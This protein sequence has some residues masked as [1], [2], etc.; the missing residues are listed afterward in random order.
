MNTWAQSTHRTVWDGNTLLI[1][2]SKLQGSLW[3][4]NREGSKCLCIESVFEKEDRIKER[5]LQVRIK[6]ACLNVEQ[7]NAE[8]PRGDE[9]AGSGSNQISPRKEGKGI[10]S[11]R[12]DASYT[13]TMTLVSED[14][15][16]DGPV[17]RGTAD[18]ENIRGLVCPL[19]PIQLSAFKFIPG[20]VNVL[21]A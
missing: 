14:V 11:T 2:A 7:K 21:N 19:S 17:R 9:V 10:Q 8:E 1:Q 12:W 18:A 5:I 3:P 20:L 15:Q 6:S 4:N 16:M 13:A